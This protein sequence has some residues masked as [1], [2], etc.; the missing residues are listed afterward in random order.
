[1]ARTR[2][3]TVHVRQWS[4]STDREAV[5]VREGFSCGAFFFSVLWALR[6]RMWLTAIFLFVASVALSLA[7]DLLQVDPVTESALGVALALIIGWEA[8]DW[9]RRSLARRGYVMAAV[10]A[11]ENLLEAERRFFART[12]DVT[13]GD[14]WTTSMVV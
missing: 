1:M 8:N 11:A 10:I 4:A 12:A 9:R 5:F 7:S 14:G 13:F 2:I 6:Y 3:Y